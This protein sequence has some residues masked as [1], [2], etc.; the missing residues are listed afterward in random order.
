MAQGGGSDGRRSLL[1]DYLRARRSVVQPEQLGL[2]R[3]SRRRVGGLRRQE[4]AAVAG[5]SY[6]YYL[7]LEQGRDRQ[8][9]EQVVA[10]LAKTLLVGDLGLRHMRRLVQLQN[11]RP[12]RGADLTRGDLRG[13]FD[14]WPRTPVAIVDANLDVVAANGLA[15]ALNG[16][17]TP[18]NNL[19]LGIFSR[20][21]QSTPL[22]RDAAERGV[23]ALRFRCDP[24]DPRLHDIVGQLSIR[25][26]VFRRIW[27]RHDSSP[28]TRGLVQ[29][30]GGDASRM[31]FRFQTLDVPTGVSCSVVAF[32]AVD[33][34]AAAAIDRIA[35]D[36]D[37]ARGKAFVSA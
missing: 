36:S 2:H 30:P 31:R 25:E 13:L 17:L 28:W 21:H 16:V 1:G 26:P 29:L 7:R 19:L 6:D 24:F 4:V 3:G 18:G 27:A 14:F 34:R 22:W 12:R 9:S 15:Q 11:A 33:R 37:G 5:I 23:A 35:S 8:P 10:A 20:E 32:H